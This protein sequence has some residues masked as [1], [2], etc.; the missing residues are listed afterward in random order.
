[1][2]SYLV[3]AQVLLHL[4]LV[5]QNPLW[6]PTLPPSYLDPPLCTRTKRGHGSQDMARQKQVQLNHGPPS[7][8]SM[9]SPIGGDYGYQLVSTDRRSWYPFCN[10]FF[11]YIHGDKTGL[12][13]GRYSF[14]EVQTGRLQLQVVSQLCSTFG[15]EQDR[16]AR[17]DGAL[18]RDV[19]RQRLGPSFGTK[20]NV[21]FA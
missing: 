17:A 15:L 14:C 4:G 21:F 6:N 16:A 3:R 12:V 9:N 18:F 1:M 19:H 11:P 8:V 13:G 2:R 20:K 5:T 10:R 7:K